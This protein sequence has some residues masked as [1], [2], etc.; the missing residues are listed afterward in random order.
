MQIALNID[1]DVLLVVKEISRQEGI[2]A[3]KI[4]SNLARQALVM[5]TVPLMRNGVPLFPRQPDAGIVT[6]ELVDK[7]MNKSEVGVFSLP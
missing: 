4:L 2:S 5:Q 6:I 7:L 3:G 1:E